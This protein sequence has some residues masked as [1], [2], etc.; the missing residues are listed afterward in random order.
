MSLEASWTDSEAGWTTE[1]GLKSG[2]GDETLELNLSAEIR[3]AGNQGW[4][5]SGTVSLQGKFFRGKD[6]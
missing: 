4:Y 1:M 3:R 5:G 6:P 2:Y